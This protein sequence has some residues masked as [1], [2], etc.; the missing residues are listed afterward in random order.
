MGTADSDFADPE[1]E[2]RA[3]VDSI[4]DGLATYEMIDGAGH[5]AHAEFPEEVA[6]VI[7]TFLG[8][9]GAA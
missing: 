6:D 3:I 9:T 7:L 4:P 8:R 2:A 5:Y 1:R